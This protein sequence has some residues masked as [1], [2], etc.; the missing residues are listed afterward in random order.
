MDTYEVGDRTPIKVKT[1]ISTEGTAFT[2]VLLNDE[3]NPGKFVADM[4]YHVTPN[5]GRKQ[6]A[7]G[8]SLK[9]R[10]VRIKTLVDFF[11][12]FP[13]EETF[14]LAVQRAKESYLAQLFGG[15]PDAFSCTVQSFPNFPRN[16]VE[17]FSEVSL[18]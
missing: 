16:G 14:N 17:F 18:T 3:N 5:I 11:I 15:N 7:G 9:G 2:F 12:D 1:A 10:T 6:I 8:S 4:A 13:N